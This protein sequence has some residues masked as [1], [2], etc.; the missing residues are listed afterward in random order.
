MEPCHRRQEGARAPTLRAC[1]V[2][3]SFT[4]CRDLLTGQTLEHGD[5]YAFVSRG[6]DLSASLRLDRGPNLEP[7]A[8]ASREHRNGASPLSMEP[9][10]AT[11]GGHS[12][13]WARALS[14]GALRR[15]PAR[16][17]DP[18]APGPA[19]AT[20]LLPIGRVRFCRDPDPQHHPLRSPAVLRAGET[21]CRLRTQGRASTPCGI[22]TALRVRRS[23]RSPPI[24]RSTSST[25][26]FRIRSRWPG[27]SSAWP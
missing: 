2:A 25:T 4:E 3:G 7:P 14:G 5:E 26:C 9:R 27:W 12:D 22:R 8:P 19:G 20:Q 17:E 1:F 21:V 15:V 6:D 11:T 10:R 13:R 23:A 16:S 18:A 24:R